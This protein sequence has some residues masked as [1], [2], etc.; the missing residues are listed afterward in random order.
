[1]LKT[2]CRVVLATTV[3]AAFSYN[4]ALAAVDAVA[5]VETVEVELT[6]ESLQKLLDESKENE[7]SCEEFVARIDHEIVRVDEVLQTEL[8]DSAPLLEE[9]QAL[10]DL[11]LNQPC[12]S[13]VVTEMQP[14]V[15]EL[16]CEECL[17]EEVPCDI[18]YEEEFLPATDGYGGCCGGGG[19]GFG[20]GGGGGFGGG[21]GW[22]G[23]AGLAGLI[24]LDNNDGPRRVSI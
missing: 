24:G 12:H 3:L 18:I 13:D 23:L 2:S 21:A 19:G 17:V 16:F 5:G 15:D 4:I 22:L 7:F 1:M 10:V 6:P 14:Y 9:R 20:G 11:R 8:A